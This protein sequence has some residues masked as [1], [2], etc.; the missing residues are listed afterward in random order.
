M[1]LTPFEIEGLVKACDKFS[2]EH[3][4]ELRLYGS[5]TQDD[6]KGGD[7]DLLLIV[8][9]DEL[10]KRL[11]LVKHNILAAM[12]IEIGEQKIDLKIVT[13]SELSTDPFLEIVY[14]GSLL[15]HR[16]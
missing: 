14:P 1:R 3:H 4:A 9:T 15:L 11:D 7:I 6:R 13:S 12:K 8:K 5:R 16:W 10:K 2:L